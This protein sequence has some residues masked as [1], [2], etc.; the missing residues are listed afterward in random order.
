[1][2]RVQG[3][4]IELVN[5]LSAALSQINRL[6]ARANEDR[7]P[8]GEIALLS[9]AADISFA[10]NH[11]AADEARVRE[12]SQRKNAE[13]TV[14]GEQRF[15]DGLIEAMPGIFYLYDERGRF[16]RWNRNF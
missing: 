6:I 10:L 11:L 4:Q 15:A 2:S 8:D 14:E 13:A 16:L 3:L 7:G 12:V 5:R 9:A 1:M